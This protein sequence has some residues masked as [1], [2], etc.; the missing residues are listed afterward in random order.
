MPTRLSRRLRDLARGIYPPLLADKGL[1][2]ALES[3]ARKATVPVR[4]EAEGVERYGQDVEATV[5]FCVLEAM[6]NVQKYANASAAVIRMSEDAGMLAFEVAD[7]G[8]G[9]DTSTVHKGAGLINMRDR[10]DA[11]GGNLEIRSAPG[12]GTR[13]RGTMPAQVRVAAQV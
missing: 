6:Q 7:N 8:M 1:V 3:Q 12:T 9:F 10:I 11:L 2:V 5:Y 4:V 13:V